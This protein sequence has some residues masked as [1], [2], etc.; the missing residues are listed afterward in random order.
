MGQGRLPAY[1]WL[2][3]GHSN[4]LVP[5]FARGPGSGSLAEQT[6]GDDPFYGPYIDQTDI[7]TLIKAALK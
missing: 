3:D 6:R 7:Y 4:A 5:V 1:R 2:S